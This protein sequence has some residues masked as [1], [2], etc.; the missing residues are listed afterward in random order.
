MIFG[1]ID[2][3]N[4]CMQVTTIISISKFAISALN[5]VCS[6]CIPLAL[7]KWIVKSRM[8]LLISKILSELTAQVIYSISHVAHRP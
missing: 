7:P 1:S 5:V 4:L 8:F 2:L 3:T 6:Y